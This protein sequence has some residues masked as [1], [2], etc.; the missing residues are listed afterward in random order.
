MNVF[1]RVRSVHSR[2][3]QLVREDPDLFAG[4]DDASLRHAAAAAVVPRITCERGP[5]EADIPNGGA[6][7]GLLVIEGLLFRNVTL[8]SHPRSEIIGPGDVIRPWERDGDLA[9]VRFETT[10]QVLE[11]ACL[12]VLDSRFLEATCRWPSITVALVGRAV[13]RCRWLTLQLAISDMRRIEDRLLLLFWHLAD[14][15]GRMSREGVIVP[16][17]LTHERLAQ[18]VGAQRPTVTTGLHRLAESGLVRRR[19]DRHWVLA[20]TP[21]SIDAVGS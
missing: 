16:I 1:D 13:S 20:P 7:L 11:P 3:I 2:P 6:L 15:W 4:L 12:A 21:P 17:R 9:S 14:R 8:R 18:L 10:W 19:E 5:W